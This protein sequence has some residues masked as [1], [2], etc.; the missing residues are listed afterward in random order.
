MRF[1]YQCCLG[2]NCKRS[3]TQRLDYSDRPLR[4]FRLGFANDAAPHSPPHDYRVASEI[5]P[6]QA[7]YLA[8]A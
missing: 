4:T 6:S 8:W 3:L 7:A 2:S 1:Y 5:V